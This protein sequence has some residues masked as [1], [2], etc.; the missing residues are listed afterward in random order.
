MD[1]TEEIRGGHRWLGA[2]WSEDDCEGCKGTFTPDK[3]WMCWKD[4][5][6]S[7]HRHFCD[8]CVIKIRKTNPF[9]L[10]ADKI[11]DE[12]LKLK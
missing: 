11:P 4:F 5:W 8:T 2:P 9:T 10:Y 1:K 3:M 7:S 6:Y 12:I